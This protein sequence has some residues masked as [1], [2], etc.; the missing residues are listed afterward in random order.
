MEDFK[1]TPQFSSYLKYHIERLHIYIY[2]Y[3]GYLAWPRLAV[4]PFHG[5]CVDSNAMCVAAVQPRAHG[6]MPGL[7]HRREWLWPW[8]SIIVSGG[9][10][11]GGGVSNVNATV[12]W[13]TCHIC[14]L[15]GAASWLPSDLLESPACQE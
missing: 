10:E 1:T 4:Q 12:A 14:S 5:G 15:D 13:I 7:S 6:E 11:A 3:G 2:I 8:L 9:R